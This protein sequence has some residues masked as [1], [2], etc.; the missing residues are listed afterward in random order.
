MAIAAKGA[1]LVD[2]E[3]KLS[4]IQIQ[5]RPSSMNTLHNP[6]ENRAQYEIHEIFVSVESRDPS[7]VTESKGDSPLGRP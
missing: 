4:R 5:S 3:F 2:A 7:A 6:T 1:C